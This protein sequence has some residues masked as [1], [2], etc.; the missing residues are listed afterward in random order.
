MHP[1]DLRSDTVTK[2]TDEM[3]AAMAAARVGDD[4][5]G[6]DPTVSELEAAAARLLGKEAGLFVSS[7]TM[8]N[9]LS[10]MAHLSRGQALI[11]ED[12]CHILRHEAGGAAYL[13]GAM[14]RPVRGVRGVMS[15]TDIEDE[16]CDGSDFHEAKTGLIAVENTHNEAGGIPMPLDWLTDL[17]ALADANG[18]PIHM[19]GARLWNAACALGVTPAA[20][21][22]VA[23][24]VTVCLSKGLSAPVGSVICGSAAFVKRARA[25][26][27]M[28]GGGMRQAGVLAAAGLVALSAVLP[29]LTEDHQNAQRLARGLAGIPGV[30]INP[31]DA[32]TNLVYFGLEKPAAPRLQTMLEEC[33]VLLFSMGGSR[34]RAVVHREIS[35]TDIDTALDAIARAV[36][37]L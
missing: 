6:E 3:R 11:C 24:S 28:I 21:C 8:G 34:A 19:D 12:R 16:I 18:L 27:K 4:V 7:G 36:A 15:L 10:L 20:A 29:R 37:K 23:D 32:P 17:R 30:I 25:F 9:Q 31:D 22:A 14:L 1:I 35:A 5:F 33:G 26:R 2:P 13:A